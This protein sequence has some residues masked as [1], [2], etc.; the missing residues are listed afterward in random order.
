[1]TASAPVDLLADVAGYFSPDVTIGFLELAPFRI[2]DTRLGTGGV[3]I[4]PLVANQM[5]RIDVAGGF[6]LDPGDLAAVILNGTVA[7]TVAPGFLTVFPCDAV[8]VPDVS[9]LNFAAGVA[10][11]NLVDTRVATDG[12]V[13]IVTSATTDVLVDIGGISSDVLG[14]FRTFPLR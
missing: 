11:P 1:M 6:G 14:A 7:N 13:R 2:I 4:A 8:S 12:T 9:N 10:V 5:L 3:S